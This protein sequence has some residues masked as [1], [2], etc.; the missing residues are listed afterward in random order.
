MD[1]QNIPTQHLRDNMERLDAE[2][3]VQESMIAGY[4][5]PTPETFQNGHIPAHDDEPLQHHMLEKFDII[6]GYD[7]TLNEQPVENQQVMVCTELLR[8][9]QTYAAFKPRTSELL[10]SLKN[11]GSQ[12]AR[13]YANSAE[14]KHQQ[15]LMCSAIAFE[16]S[17]EEITAL[18]HISSS[19]VA[20][21]WTFVNDRL[22][23]GNKDLIDCRVLKPKLATRFL[24]WIYPSVTKQTPV[25][26][27]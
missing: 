25:P 19:A 20:T 2:P 9:L 15:V 6:P 17:T 11:K 4:L 16:P 23:G 21:K 22:A 14:W 26:V 1:G 18:A 8:Q 7:V 27:N 24:S 5:L 13:P 10:L 12:L 3:S